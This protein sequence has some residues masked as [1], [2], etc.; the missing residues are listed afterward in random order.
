M[1]TFLKLTFS[2]IVASCMASCASNSGMAN[3]QNPPGAPMAMDRMETRE[4]AQPRPLS[5]D[6]TSP[7]NEV[8]V[9]P[10]RVGVVAAE[11]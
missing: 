5:S 1:K 2:M 9:E 7:L 11:F 6:D 8:M 3:V 10:G 4:Y